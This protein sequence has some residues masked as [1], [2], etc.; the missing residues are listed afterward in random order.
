MLSYSSLKGKITLLVAAALLAVTLTAVLGALRARTAMVDARKQALVTAVEATFN[1]VADY[2][3]K[4][5]S[6][7]MPKDQAQKAAAEALRASRFGG[8]DGKSEY[9]FIW[10]LA[11]E[12]VMHPIK[13]EWQGQNMTG[14][15]KDSA[16]VDVIDS[17]TSLLKRSSTGKGFLSSQFT[18]PGETSLADK[19]Y[20]VM[21]VEGWNW[22]VGS[23]LYTDDIDKMVMRN[24]L[25]DAITLLVTLVVLGALGGAVARS[26]LRQVGGEP[27]VACDAMSRIA[28]GDLAV[29]LPTSIPPGSIMDG[30][31][32]MT[33][34]LSRLVAEVRSSTGSITATS[35]EIATSSADLSS[36]TEEQAASL[37]E[38]AASM[39]E[40]ASTVRLNADNARQASQLAAGTSE[41]A[42]RG[43]SAVAEVV[44]TMNSISASSSRIYEIVSV[45]DGI[46]FQ[47]NILALN[48]AVEAARAG[49]QGKGFAVVA[50][51]VRS[52]AQRSAQAAKEIKHLIEDAASTVGVGAQQVQRAG[53]TMEEIVTSVKRVTDIMREI[54]SASEEQ[55]T[56]INQVNQ[57]VS[58]MDGVTQQNAMMVEAAAAASLSL[59]DDARRLSDTVSAF[60]LAEDGLLK[61]SSS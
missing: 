55:S 26:V 49:E 54:S 44:D 10:T 16:G 39:E 22:M 17:L 42:E 2:K 23:G 34:A 4:A 43:G 40:L 56:G 28:K 52:L 11:N 14:K 46:A 24:A 30:V 37:E 53:S 58:Q 47:T 5:D 50:G 48:A 32:Q 33:N 3:A 60:S 1:I 36:R 45:I 59:R 41:I 20:Y 51:E 12:S 57:V 19:L 29:Q 31:N 15:V 21:K 61:S 6:G 38:A 13:P 8:P 35:D 7:A 9:F 27:A 18:R 25:D